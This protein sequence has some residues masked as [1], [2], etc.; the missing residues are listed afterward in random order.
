MKIKTDEIDDLLYWT[1]QQ[2]WPVEQHLVDFASRKVGFVNNEGSCGVRYPGSG[3]CPR[4][5]PG[6]VAVH[7]WRQGEFLAVSEVAYLNVMT[8]FL[9]DRGEDD[10]ANSL[11]VPE[12]RR[13][14]RLVLDL[15]GAGTVSILLSYLKKQLGLLHS[16]M[17]M[18][19]IKQAMMD[20]RLSNMPRYLMIEGFG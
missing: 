5:L 10:L 12:S 4:I 14:E 20:D 13:R 18:A 11:P 3:G 17:G 1:L 9:R 16:E 6:Q 15:A 2:S 8:Q 19:G 7:H